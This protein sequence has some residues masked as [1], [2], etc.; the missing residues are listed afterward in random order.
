MGSNL[1]PVRSM[2]FGRMAAIGALQPMADDV[3]YGRRCP[4]CDIRR[5]TEIDQLNR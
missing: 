4:F 5:I 3:P 2:A 1:A